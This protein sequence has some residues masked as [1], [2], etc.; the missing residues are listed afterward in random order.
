MQLFPPQPPE[1]REKSIEDDSKKRETRDGINWARG[2]R[3]NS[4]GFLFIG[5]SMFILHRIIIMFLESM[6]TCPPFL[7]ILSFCLSIRLLFC[8]WSKKQEEEGWW[9]E[10]LQK[11]NVSSSWLSYCLGLYTGFLPAMKLQKRWGRYVCKHTLAMGFIL[12]LP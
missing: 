9:W 2:S 11:K 8:V 6:E 4:R 7:F 5:N 10:P 1:Q 12:L 3:V